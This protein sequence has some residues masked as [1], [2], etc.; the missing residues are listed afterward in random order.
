MKKVSVITEITV[1]D[2]SYLAKYKMINSYDVIIY[3]GFI[4]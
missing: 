1:Q 4:S 2:E 3:E